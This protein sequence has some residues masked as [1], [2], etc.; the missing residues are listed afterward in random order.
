MIRYRKTRYGSVK[1]PGGI[2]TI[3]HV[4][5]KYPYAAPT[6]GIPSDMVISGMIRS[7]KAKLA[8]LT[9]DDLK[10]LSSFQA[11]L[12][13]D[14]GSLTLSFAGYPEADKTSAASHTKEYNVLGIKFTGNV[15]YSPVFV[16]GRV[17]YKADIKVN[18]ATVQTITAND[19]KSKQT[20]KED[21]QGQNIEVCGYYGYENDKK[22]SNEICTKIEVPEKQKRS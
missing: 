18:G 10:E 11:T 7:D 5:G 9:A 12:N 1:N 3:S 22:R 2:S 15:Y 6:E 14:D 8:A 19:P 17:V 16:F 20:L 13:K 4:K 21:Y